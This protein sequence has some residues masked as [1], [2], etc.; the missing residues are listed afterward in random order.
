[1][2]GAS[3]PLAAKTHTAP[4]PP[5]SPSPPTMTVVSSP[6]IATDFPC[7]AGPTAPVPTSLL[8]CCDHTALFRVYTHTAPVLEL[9]RGAPTMAVFPSAEIATE[10]TCP[11]YQLASV[12]TSLLPCWMNWTCATAACAR[13]NIPTTAPACRAMAH[14]RLAPHQR[15]LYYCRMRRWNAA[16]G[17]GVAGPMRRPVAGAGP[18]RTG[19]PPRPSA[20]PAWKT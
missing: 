2:E 11:A 14:P 3:Q 4:I 8:P 16:G 5:A 17:L 12:P 6:E 15:N 13:N 7:R 18:H 9:S 1:M 20:F 19:P 10:V